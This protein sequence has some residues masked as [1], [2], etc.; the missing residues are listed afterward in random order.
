MKA[1]T[2]PIAKGRY[3]NNAGAI[4]GSAQRCCHHQKPTRH[5]ANTTSNKALTTCCPPCK[6]TKP[7]SKHSVPT[8]AKSRPRQ[9]SVLPLPGCTPPG[10]LVG[11]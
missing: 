3:A 10:A 11:K 4:K 6:F 9:S 5:T 7:L 8:V 2:E 1:T